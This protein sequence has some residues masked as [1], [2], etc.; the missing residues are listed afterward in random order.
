MNNDIVES[1]IKDLA[2]EMDAT[3]YVFFCSA[4]AKTG[5]YAQSSN[6]DLQSRI[7][8]LQAVIKD[9]KAEFQQT[10]H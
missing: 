8:F 2:F 1:L 4:D 3:P 6:L 9:L 7:K 5:A 10:A